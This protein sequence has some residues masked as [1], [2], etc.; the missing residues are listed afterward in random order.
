MRIKL[1]RWI[2]ALTIVIVLL[3][4][5]PVV[6]DE[7]LD[8]NAITQKSINVA[9]VPGA[10]QPRILAIV[11]T[12]IF[13]AV[14]GIERRFTPIH[15][16]AEAPKGASR[17]AAA[18]QAAYTALV[19]LFPAQSAALGDDLEKSL[20]AIA[21]DAAVENSSSIAIGRMW[22]EQVANEIL[23]WRNADGLAPPGPPY[24]GSLETGKWRPTPPAFLPGLAPTLAHT[25]P[26]VIPSPSSFRPQGPPPLSS[27]EYAESFNEVKAIG[28]LTSTVRTPDQTQSAIFW[29]GTAATFWNR[30]A[31]SAALQRHTTLSENSRLLAV[32]NVAMADALIAA[33]DSKYHFEFWRPITAIPLASTDG[34]DATVEKADWTPLLVTPNYPEYYSGH[35]SVDGTS[36]AILTAYFGSMLPVE[37]FSEGL[38]GVV[39][40]WPNFAAAADEALLAR[41]WG[42]IHF[43][44]SML[45]TRAVAEQIAAYVLEHAAQPLN[46][47]R[48]GQLT[49]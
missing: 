34:N 37:G 28:E 31:V 11:H 7:V 36:Q 6:A 25:L 15:V 27:A 2:Y 4:P 35:Q 49:K 9:K 30:A 24:L 32:L 29:A 40:S 8:W 5:Q 10:L 1:V 33:W 19:S 41:I 39:R 21:S 23:A 46:G 45:D 47:N 43:R 17:R 12:S 26:F 16:D 48:V 18:V 14:N 20:D 13:D 38:P 3:A 22:G 44:F 42:G